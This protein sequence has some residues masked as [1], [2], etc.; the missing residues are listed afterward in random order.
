M[1]FFAKG[2]YGQF[3]LRRDFSPFGKTG[4]KSVYRLLFNLL[5]AKR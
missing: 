2:G 5:F 1:M 3:Y 4:L